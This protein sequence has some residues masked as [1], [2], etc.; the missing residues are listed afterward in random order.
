MEANKVS[1]IITLNP[2]ITVIIM[3]FLG[4]AGVQ[5]IT[6]EHFS[7]LSIIGAALALSGA[8]FV[9]FFTRRTK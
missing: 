8:A 1:L 2:V 5:W 4:E 3:F 7:L 6:P 9:V